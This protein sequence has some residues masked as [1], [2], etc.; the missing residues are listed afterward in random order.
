MSRFK[1]LIIL[2]LIQPIL[3]LLALLV[4]W[5]YTRGQ[6]EMVYTFVSERSPDE[7][8]T[9][10]LSETKVAPTGQQA[11][12][13][14]KIEGIGPKISAIF[15]SA[16]ITTYAQLAGREVA[17]LETILEQA[18]IRNA[19]PNTWPEQANLAAA[20]DWDT[21]KSLQAQLKGGRRA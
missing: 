14:K 16:G 5:W 10:K 18:G 7:P 15:Y 19:S 12:D 1:P 6:N 17:S 9:P 13:L 20:G 2:L 11:D 21:L 8:D 4:W 3:F